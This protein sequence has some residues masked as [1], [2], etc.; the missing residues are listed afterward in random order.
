MLASFAHKTPA[1]AHDAQDARDARPGG[2]KGSTDAH[3]ARPASIRGQLMLMMLVAG[4]LLP[5][6]AN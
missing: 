2:E 6:H 5:Q 4:R 3:D 1:D